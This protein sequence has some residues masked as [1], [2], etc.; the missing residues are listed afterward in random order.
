MHRQKSVKQT[1]EWEDRDGRVGRP[2]DAIFVARLHGLDFVPR[3]LGSQEGF[4]QGRDKVRI[5]FCK[6]PLATS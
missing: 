3:A 5:G 6:S 4:K 2:D 1:G